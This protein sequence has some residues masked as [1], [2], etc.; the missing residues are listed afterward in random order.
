MSEVLRATW[1][2]L[3]RLIQSAQDELMVCTPYYSSEGIGR[4]FDYLTA[5]PALTL[6]VRLSPSAWVRGVSDPEALSVLLQLCRDEAIATRLYVHQRL[7]AK[8]YLAD[9]SSGLV[10]SANLSSGGFAGNFEVMVKI[11]GEDA[12]AAHDLVTCEATE[13]GRELLIDDLQKWVDHHSGT[14][15]AVSSKSRSEAEELADVQRDLDEML[16]HG[17]GGPPAVMPTFPPMDEFVAWLEAHRTLAG[18]G[19]LIDRHRNTSGQNLQGHFKQS[20]HAARN[21]L[22]LETNRIAGISRELADIEADAVYQPDEALTAA[23][24]AHLDSNAQT[25]ACDH[26]YAVLRGILPP[27]LGGTREGGGGGSST[28]KRMIPLVA[29]FLEERG[30]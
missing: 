13:R 18:A 17:A 12:Q 11:D 8:V 28:F 5:G 20:Y 9:R 6:I 16:G 21:F 15:A 27:S 29:R 3:E 23:W 10:G 4:L 30:G 2:D 7:H 1:R 14:V 19:V 24:V 25:T 26:D 22:G